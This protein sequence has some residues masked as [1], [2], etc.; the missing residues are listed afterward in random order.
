MC[1]IELRLASAIPTISTNSGDP[2]DRRR[3]LKN[4]GALV[5]AGAVAKKSFADVLS[6]SSA[7]SIRRLAIDRNWRYRSDAPSEFE[8]VGFDDSGFE[9]VVVPHTNKRLPCHS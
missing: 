9:R 7:S 1:L 6:T 5:A 4:A 8:A 2:M 3:F